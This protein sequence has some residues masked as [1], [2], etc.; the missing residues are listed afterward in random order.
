MAICWA[1]LGACWVLLLIFFYEGFFGTFLICGAIVTAIA[2]WLWFK[3]MGDILSKW[4][5]VTAIIWISLCLTGVVRLTIA[6]MNAP[7]PC[8]YCGGKG[9]FEGGYGVGIIDCP[10]C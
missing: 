10:D 5:L 7:D 2:L 1:I 8:R 4:A 6:D 3:G 9:Y